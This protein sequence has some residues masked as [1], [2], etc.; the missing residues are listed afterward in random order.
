[1]RQEEA[2]TGIQSHYR[3][4]I[5]RRQFQKVKQLFHS[6]KVLKTQGP[7]LQLLKRNKMGFISVHFVQNK[8]SIETNTSSPDT[9]HIMKVWAAAI[10]IQSHVQGWLQRSRYVLL[11]AN[12]RKIQL[13]YRE[14]KHY[15]N[16][17]KAAVKIQCT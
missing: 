11:V 4:L 7:G 16:K 14:Y 6:Y 12:V 1:M 17:N 5:E 2:S 15:V 8:E 9:V 13:K 3:G 10:A